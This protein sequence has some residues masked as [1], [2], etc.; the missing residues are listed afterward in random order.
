MAINRGGTVTGSYVDRNQ[1]FHC[2]VRSRDGNITSFDAA[3]SV[4]TI[5]D[6]NGINRSGA[7]SGGYLTADGVTHG[8]VRN[9]E[10]AITRFDASDAGTVAGF[11]SAA[12]MINDAGTIPGFSLDNN[13]V[14][15]GFI[16][17]NDG[18]FVT[19]DAPGAGTGAIKG[20]I[21]QGTFAD[22]TNLAGTTAGTYTDANYVN[23]GFV[24]SRHGRIT[25]FDMPGEGTGPGQGV[26]AVGS[27]NS[28]GAVVGWYVDAN[29]ANHGFIYE[30]EDD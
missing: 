11:G 8:F 7:I 2:F 9:P 13:G 24:R 25:T 3:G 23:H 26:F 29:G 10:G 19:F 30:R 15:H 5:G 18:T 21:V 6:T 20:N 17:G 16:R 12:N 27:I 1:A 22:A 4:S 28:D 14:S